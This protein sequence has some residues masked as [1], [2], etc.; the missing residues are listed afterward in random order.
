MVVAVV[1]LTSS[2]STWVRHVGGYLNLAAAG[3]RN[4]SAGT[5]PPLHSQLFAF[6]LFFLSVGV[7][8]MLSCFCHVL[9]AHHLFVYLS[10]LSL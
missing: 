2:S 1:S 10:T 3:Q 8:M 4:L 6:F 9:S 7:M 5:T